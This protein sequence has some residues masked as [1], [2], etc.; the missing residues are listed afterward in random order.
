MRLTTKLNTRYAQRFL[1]LLLLSLAGRAGAEGALNA[2]FAERVKTVKVSTALP[3]K[4]LT[5]SGV[6]ACDPDRSVSYVPLAN[7]I[8]TRTAFALGAKVE[9]GQAMLDIRSPELGTLQA[10]MSSVEAELKSAL[11][12]LKWAE[13]MVADKLLSEKELAEAQEKV[14]LAEAAK[15]RVQTE[16]EMF[17]A[18]KGRGVFSVLAPMGGHIITKQVAEGMTVAGGEEPLFTV[19]DLGT[20]W[21]V[22]NIYASNIAFVQDGMEAHVSCISYPGQVFTSKV[23]AVSQVFDPE[24]KAL[25]ARIVLDN[26]DMKFKPGMS[27]DIRFRQ[28]AAQPLATLPADALIFDN[29]RHYAVV[30]VGGDRFAIREVTVFDTHQGRTFL[31]SGLQEGD[32]V[33]VRNQILVYAELTGI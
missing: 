9:K 28:A 4:E 11:R 1:G 17:G 14:G 8:V 15:E 12:G 26:A 3:A 18:I 24:D 7:G 16:L 2:A 33:V 13:E 32:E 29:N 22:A 25:K 30:R 5:V 20:V 6:V 23:D 19:A 21:V 10:E 31:A 27:V